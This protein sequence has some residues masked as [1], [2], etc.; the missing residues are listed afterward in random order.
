MNVF[1]V[2]DVNVPLSKTFTEGFKF[3]LMKP[4]QQRVNPLCLCMFNTLKTLL[5]VVRTRHT[6]AGGDFPLWRFLFF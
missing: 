3:G 2:D 4:S 6:K 5:F 1:L